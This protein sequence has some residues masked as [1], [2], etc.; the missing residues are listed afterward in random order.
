M[1]KGYFNIYINFFLAMLGVNNAYI[2][3]QPCRTTLVDQKV[4]LTIV[5]NC[6]FSDS[7]VAKKV[8]LTIL[9]LYL[10]SMTTHFIQKIQE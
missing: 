4:N 5:F 10:Y 3:F 7:F 9:L 6:T 1:I 8:N 2:H